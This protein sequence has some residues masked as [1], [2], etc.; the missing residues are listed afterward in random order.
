MADMIRVLLSLENGTHI[1]NKLYLCERHLFGHDDHNH[2]MTADHRHP[3]SGRSLMMI[4][5]APHI[6]GQK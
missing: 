6:A 5:R 4:S 3:R 1:S 2:R